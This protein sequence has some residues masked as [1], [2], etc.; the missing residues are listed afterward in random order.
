ML[1]DAP[2]GAFAVD[3]QPPPETGVV[4]IDSHVLV[5]AAHAVPTAQSEVVA[6]EVRHLPARQRN[7]AHAWLTPSA[8]IAAVPSGEHL[9]V[10]G[11]QVDDSQTKPTAQSPSPA[12]EVLHATALSSHAKPLHDT[13][14]TAGQFPLPSHTAGTVETPSAHAA[15]RHFVSAPTFPAHAVV[16]V[17]SQAEA[18]QTFEESAAHV[19]RVPCG[20]PTTGVHL[21]MLSATSHAAH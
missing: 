5:L 2:T 17:P 18:P 4:A 15:A 12:Q 6:H 13:V 16:V 3:E 7:G 11:L 14:L 8:W 9:S 19:A 1:P 10:I 20:A 21:P